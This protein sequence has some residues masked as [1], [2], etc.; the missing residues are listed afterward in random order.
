VFC[1]EETWRKKKL[2]VLLIV[3]LDF[4][5]DERAQETGFFSQIE[6]LILF[7]LVFFVFVVSG[8]LWVK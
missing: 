6:T 3:P 7:F 5:C 8:F 1:C 2:N 4:Q